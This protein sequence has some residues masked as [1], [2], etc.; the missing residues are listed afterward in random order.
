MQDKKVEFTSPKWTSTTKLVIALLLIAV[1]AALFFRFNHIL[2]PLLLAFLL[3]YLFYPLADI[4]KL[5][6][7]FSW[8]LSVTIIYLIL[9]I[10][11]IGLLT[12]G[13]L[14][15]FE[16]LSSLIKFI[17]VEI[18]NVPS[19]LEDL[20]NQN[21]V[22]GPFAIDFS[23]MD[24]AELGNQL[25]GVVQP[26]ISQLGTL[27]GAVAAGA[28]STIGW[29]FFSFLI[30]YFILS[31]ARGRRS[32]LVKINIPGYNQDISRISRELGSTWN[33]FLRGQLLIILLT[34]VIYTFVLVVL[35][36]NFA[37]G[38]AIVAGLARFIPYVGPVVAWTTYGLVTLFQ[39]ST[40]FGLES[41]Q[42]ALLVILVA[43]VIDLIL[44]NI[45]VPRLM[46]E[47][48]EVH[49][50]AVMVAAIIFASLFGLVGVILAAPV[51]ATAKLFGQYTFNK[52][53]DLD[54][55]SNIERKKYDRPKNKQQLKKFLEIIKS[56]SQRIQ[57]WFNI[58]I[59]K[60]KKYGVNSVKKG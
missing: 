43:W 27:V 16:Q 9:F 42:Y 13:G 25:L 26:I 51:L 5:K 38:L 24:L 45:V 39:D 11:F 40:I 28:A 34:I 54:P 17:Q 8:R 7:K 52:M 4:I 30:S 2:G 33:A 53:F 3:A 35:R 46:G 29:V 55:W 49:P 58:K 31:E 44:D 59:K 18:N 36:V 10:V 41:F 15:I 32:D 23:Q 21:F 56:L 37:F 20:S 57:N 60:N 48:L 22:F 14:T 50:A 1:F 19:Y 6:I 47:A 12:W